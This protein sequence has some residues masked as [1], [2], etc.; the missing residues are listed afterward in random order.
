MGHEGGEGGEEVR[1][2]S[3]A[4][5]VPAA[6]QHSGKVEETWRPDSTLVGSGLGAKC[7]I[8]RLFGNDF[9]P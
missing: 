1:D 4:G 5:E 7:F 6:T 2:M 8:G 9:P 3:E